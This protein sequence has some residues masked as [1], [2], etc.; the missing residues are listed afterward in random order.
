LQI[1]PVWLSIDDHYSDQPSFD[2]LRGV[3]ESE[4]NEFALITGK[5]SHFLR[6]APTVAACPFHDWQKIRVIGERHPPD[7]PLLAP[8]TNERAFFA[9]PGLHHCAH[10]EV[11][12]VIADHGS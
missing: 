6:K 4:K 5:E 12:Q 10:Q 9:T 7:V 2:L 1:E 11:G 8:S 3:S